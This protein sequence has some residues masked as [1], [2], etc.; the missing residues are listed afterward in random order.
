MDQQRGPLG[1][2]GVGIDLD[3]D[4][5]AVAGLGVDHH[6]RRLL[7]L[8]L[9]EVVERRR[10]GRRQRLRGVEAG[11]LD[12]G[13]LT[14]A[15]T[16]VEVVRRRRDR[17]HVRVAG[18]RGVVEGDQAAGLGRLVR[19]RVEVVGERQHAER[20]GGGAVV[21]DDQVAALGLTEVDRL[22]LALA[23]PAQI[24]AHLHAF[25]RDLDRAR[26][27]A[28]DLLGAAPVELQLRGRLTGPQHE[29]LAQRLE[30]LR[31]EGFRVGAQL[32]LLMPALD[33]DLDRVAPQDLALALGQHFDLG[34]LRRRGGAVSAG[35]RDRRCQDEARDQGERH[36]QPSDDP[37][38]LH[39]CC[40]PHCACFLRVQGID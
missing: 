38:R 34:L 15:E 24:K 2:R 31:V 39:S 1:G 20:V 17:V 12:H 33:P 7:A 25:A 36:G 28:R 6:H 16:V 4:R 14:R 27:A 30:S 23:G 3:P 5:P 18:H 32:E 40:L 26:G 37:S 19:D 8:E 11:H 13:R 9:P 10:V 35:S 29:A 22:R 21:D